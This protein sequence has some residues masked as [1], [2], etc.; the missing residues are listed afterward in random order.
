MTLCFLGSLQL[1]LFANSFQDQLPTAIAH[2]L[3]ISLAQW[4][5]PQGTTDYFEQIK[6]TVAGYLIWSTFPITVSLPTKPDFDPT[7]AT[8]KRWQLWENAVRQAIAEWTIYLPLAIIP[9]TEIADITIK[10]EFP[11]PEITI[12][13]QT[14]DR[15][16]SLA[17]NAQTR[18]QF[19]LQK[20]DIF[21]HRMTIQLAPHQNY[22]ATLA[23]IRHEL[24]HALGLW[25]HSPSS[26]DALYSSQTANLSPISNAD[27]NTLKRLYQQPTPLGW[28]LPKAKR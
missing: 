5:A 10:Q 11:P 8:A 1:A 12:D 7:S 24:G 21:A 9:D 20:G 17:S 22:L 25:G 4:Q 27:I 14:G 28:P 23:T 16:V 6:P 19:Y 13:P 2:P 3:P 18:Y 15:Q 26:N